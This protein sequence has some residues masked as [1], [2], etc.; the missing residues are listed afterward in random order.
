MSRTI[1]EIIEQYG[2]STRKERN[3]VS[4]IEWFSQH[5]GERFDR[6]EVHRE[7][8]KELDVGQRSVG[9]YLKEL[10]EEGVL[11]S[12]GEQR[13]SYR[14]EEDIVIPVKYQIRA[15]GRHLVAIFDVARW[16]IVGYLVISTVFWGILTLPFWFFSLLLFIHPRESIGLIHES[17]IYLFAI[18]M[19]AWLL[20]FVISS[21][22]L[23]KIRSIWLSRFSGT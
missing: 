3:K 12:Y 9:D 15:A 19:T 5:P 2:D 8:A 4:I 10:D 1:S 17:E 14:L 21:F 16:G 18:A 22:L 11:H 7:L 20:L 23:W 13:I 6:N